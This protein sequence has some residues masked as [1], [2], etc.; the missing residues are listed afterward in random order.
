MIGEVAEWTNASGLN[1]EA[2]MGRGFESH[3]LLKMENVPMRVIGD[4][5][6]SYGS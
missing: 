2:L 3:P 5:S 4:D 6:K 1:P